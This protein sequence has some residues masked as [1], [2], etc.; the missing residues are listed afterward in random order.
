MNLKALFFSLFL[1]FMFLTVEGYA[2]TLTVSVDY[3]NVRAGPG[4]QHKVVSV[5]KK[6]QQFLIL[7]EQN[8]WYRISVEGTV[9]W[10]SGR[11][12]TVEEGQKGVDKG[13]HLTT[14]GGHRLSEFYRK[15][16][17]VI[18]GINRY[19][20]W[21]GLEFAVNDAR[22]VQKRL[23]SLGFDEIITLTDHQ[24]TR[25]NILQLMG[26]RLPRKV[27][28]TDE[29]K[30]SFQTKG[31]RESEWNPEGD[32]PNLYEAKTIKGKP[33]VID[34]ASGLMWQQSGSSKAMTYKDAQAYLKRL[35]QRRYAG[36]KDWRLPTIEELGSLIEPT[37]RNRKLFIDL[38][39]DPT[40]KWCWS[41]DL[42]D[43]EINDAS[44]AWGVGFEG[45]YVSHG[46]SGDQGYLR[47]VRPL[48]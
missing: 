44:V 23:K 10:V 33:L 17:A 38:V 19:E 13:I 34:H 16:W 14:P 7:N 28:K 5:V 36:F 46:F 32:F 42:A 24:A 45:G 21:P 11:A 27:K 8:G 29:I 30:E 41:A 43:F 22:A 18:I 2:G 37:A 35:N 31:L 9:G 47:G 15:S 25:R 39:F 6:N 40:Q 48:K 4:L 3:L 26:D 12:V 20:T 1:L